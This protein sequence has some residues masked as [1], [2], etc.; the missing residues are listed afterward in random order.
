[1][2]ELSRIPQESMYDSFSPAEEEYFQPGTT[3]D[4]ILKSPILAKFDDPEAL[5]ADE[6]NSEAEFP[7]PNQAAEDKSAAT[8]LTLFLAEA[9]K[10][11]LL[12]P[13]KE[14]ALAKE[15]D[16]YLKYREEFMLEAEKNS[17][18]IFWEK[19]RTL[20]P[21]EQAAV[22]RGKQAFELFMNSNL[23]LV[24]SVVK[25]YRGHGLPFL[26]L[27]QEGCIGLNRAVEKFDWTKGFKF[28]TYATWWIRQAAQRAV[29]NQ[30]NTIRIPVHIGERVAKIKKFEEQF[31]KEHGCSPSDEDIEKGT[32]ISL[33]GI[34]QTKAAREVLNIAS[35]DKTIGDEY[36]NSFGVFVADD[37]AEEPLSVVEE[38][39]KQRLVQD[40][41]GKLS[42]RE[43]IVLEMRYGFYEKKPATLDEIGKAIGITRERVRQ[44]ESKALHRLAALNNLQDINHAK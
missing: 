22:I 26:D 32:G 2:S 20:P 7:T 39:D 40:A 37:E 24:V 28:S 8:S 21:D 19:I 25:K 10:Y 36:E 35:L 9:A 3:A 18:E 17:E 31:S 33:V 23:R 30:G 12:T 15:K 38:A 16:V 14:V 13:A 5:A 11:P 27:I 1:M 34:K 42:E 44:L 43:R 6:V 41:L 4:E 29:S